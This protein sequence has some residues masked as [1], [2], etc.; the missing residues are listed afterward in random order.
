M[1]FFKIIIRYYPNIEW[2]LFLRNKCSNGA[3]KLYSQCCVYTDDKPSW[4]IINAADRNVAEQNGY[5][6]ELLYGE[7]VY[8]GVRWTAFRLVSVFRWRRPSHI[9]INRI[10]GAYLSWIPNKRS[11]VRSKQSRCA[12]YNYKR[13]MQGKNWPNN[14]AQ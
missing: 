8:S 10:K 11:R 12:A 5:L 6:D 13:V 4:K 1:L 3:Q 7:K 9:F 14:D 2:E